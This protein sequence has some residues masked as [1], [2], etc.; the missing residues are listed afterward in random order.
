MAT[1]ANNP[2][3]ELVHDIPVKNPIDT[4]ANT[5]PLAKSHLL[6]QIDKPVFT[7]PKNDEDNLDGP[8]PNRA[9]PAKRTQKPLSNVGVPSSSFPIILAVVACSVALVLIVVAVM[10]FRK[11]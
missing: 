4:T 6:A 9:A 2:G 11:G 3:P 10:V 7:P 8:A 1:T 5:T